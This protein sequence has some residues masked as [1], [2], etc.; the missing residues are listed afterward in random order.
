MLL[1]CCQ[2]TT[3]YTHLEKAQEGRCVPVLGFVIKSGLMQ[4]SGRP[5]HVATICPQIELN[6]LTVFNV[7]VQPL[8]SKHV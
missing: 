8:F 5:I 1:L 2:A 6:V 3:F 7:I 4:S